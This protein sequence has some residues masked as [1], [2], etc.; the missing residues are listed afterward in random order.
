VYCS[1]LGAQSE[2][3]LLLSVLPPGEYDYN[4]EPIESLP[5]LLVS[6]DDSRPAF[7]DSKRT[8]RVFRRS[9]EESRSSGVLR[10]GS[11]PEYVDEDVLRRL[12]GDYYAERYHVTPEDKRT[13]RVM[14]D[15][16]TIR[17]VD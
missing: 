4:G 10:L 16:R 17:V 12:L 6:A 14:N 1:F 15:K 7:R 2:K 8:I 5:K 11:R 13:I 9:D 3:D